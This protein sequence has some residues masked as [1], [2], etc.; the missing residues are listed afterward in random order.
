MGGGRPPSWLPLP[1]T[2]GQGTLFHRC[3]ELAE[4]NLHRPF[5]IIGDFNTGRNDLDIEGSGV[6][7]YCADQFAGL[8]EQAG[9]TDLW[10]LRHGV[11]AFQE[12]QALSKSPTGKGANNQGNTIRSGLP[13]VCPPVLD[14]DECKGGNA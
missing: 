5:V 3:I 4:R 9:L 12:D 14:L 8:P 2:N 7:F 1:S 11:G 6:P 13:P 10:R